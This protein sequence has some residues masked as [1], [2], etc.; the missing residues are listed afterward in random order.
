MDSLDQALVYLKKL[1]H[2]QPDHGVALLLTGLVHEKAKQWDAA[3]KAYSQY[4]RLNPSSPLRLRLE[5]RLGRIR[6]EA[7]KKAL[8]T[9]ENGNSWSL[10]D[11]SIAVFP[12]HYQSNTTVRDTT[13]ADKQAILA[14]VMFDHL[15][16]IASLRP[17]N[18]ALTLALQ[19]NQ[20][21]LL[22][23][24]AEA[25]QFPSMSRFFRATHISQLK[26]L[27][28]GKDFSR[29]RQMARLARSHRLV[30]GSFSQQGEDRFKLV[31]YLVNA[32]EGTQ[33]RPYQY[34]GSWEGA[35]DQIA[36]FETLGQ[37]TIDLVEKG[38][39]QQ[40]TDKERRR[41]LAEPP[42]EILALMAYYQE[43]RRLEYRG[44]LDAARQQYAQGQAI[45]PDFDPLKKGIKRIGSVVKENRLDP[46]ESTV[47]ENRLGPQES[48]YEESRFSPQ[49]ATAPV[50]GWDLQESLGAWSREVGVA[51]DQ[52]FS[53]M[54]PR[55]RLWH[56][57]QFTGAGFVP[58][59]DGGQAEPT[60]QPPIAPETLPG[61]RVL[62]DVEIVVPLPTTDK[63][64]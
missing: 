32:L 36:V 39:G 14:E 37:A 20:Y 62:I 40:V 63:G 21:V 28:R 34:V 1:R 54:V 15:T 51:L 23:M 19:L 5:T 55:E 43:G 64:P 17:Q 44:N 31:L 11:S 16:Q 9:D 3:L 47:K 48:T 46:Q 42:N 56:T 38:M 12:F 50:P 59:G 33:Q 22:N 49:A 10:S 4:L 24:F 2:L 58:A 8:T 35:L 60:L 52:R 45:D 29:A 41:I 6:S 27:G 30:L 13:W 53:R 26:N 7:F 18:P 57:A 25:E 61:S